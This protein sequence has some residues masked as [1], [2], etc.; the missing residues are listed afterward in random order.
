MKMI[1]LALLVVTMVA[2]TAGIQRPPPPTITTPLP[3][4]GN[5]SYCPMIFNH[6]QEGCFYV[7]QSHKKRWNKAEAVCQGYGSHVHLATL[8]RRQV[9]TFMLYH[10]RTTDGTI[11]VVPSFHYC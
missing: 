11:P 10:S 7:D 2:L 8:D 9:G 1:K 3:S 5:I 4:T 6:T